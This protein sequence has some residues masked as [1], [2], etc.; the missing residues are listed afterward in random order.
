MIELIP[1]KSVL[2]ETL[3]DYNL[4]SYIV[5]RFIPLKKKT[6][7]R[8]YKSNSNFS[9]FYVNDNTIRIDLKE[10]KSLKYIVSV[11]LHEIRHFVQ[12]KKVK[13]KLFFNY[14]NYK[15]YYTSPEEKDAR[16]FEKLTTE[17]CHIY[18]NYLKIAAKISNLNLDSFKE[19][20]YNGREIN[21]QEKQHNDNATIH[22]N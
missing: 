13:R 7:I 14:K 18:Q 22:R 15:E 10:G 8:V 5:S 16:K 11:I 2:D 17:V 6:Q 20:E 21:K 1:S 4:L 12:I 9:A 19:L 3:I